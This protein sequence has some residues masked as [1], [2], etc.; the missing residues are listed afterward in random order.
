MPKILL[1]QGPNMSYLGRRQ[2]EL[3]GKTSAAELDAMLREHAQ[4]NGYELT[5]FYTHSESAAIERLYRAVEEGFDGLVMN[6]AAFLFAGHALRD[7]LRAV[8]LPY[9]EVHMTN[10]E[11][12]GLR[13]ILAETGV[14]LIA[15]FGVQS[16]LLGLEAMLE[17]LKHRGRVRATSDRP[18][19]PADAGRGDGRQASG[20]AAAKR[21]MAS[22]VARKS[23]RLGS[24]AARREAPRAG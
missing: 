9:I 22:G 16:Y 2:P 8:P 19:H 12:R 4:V 20:A 24:E 14:G 11:K 6:P 10:I 3:Y 21:T 17:H 7:C 13:S 15:G 5:I 23:R 1:I 18:G